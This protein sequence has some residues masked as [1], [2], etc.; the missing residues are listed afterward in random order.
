MTCNS[1]NA[2]TRCP[3][4]EEWPPLHR[5]SWAAA[6]KKGGL[7]DEP[8]RAA[9][10]RPATTEKTRKGYGA[11]LNWMRARGG[12]DCDLID[13]SRPEDF[14]TPDV[15][16]AYIDHLAARRSSMTVYNRIQELYGAIRVMAP[17][18]DWSWLKAAQDNLLGR[19]R[20]SRNKL[21]RLKDGALIE[22]LGMRLMA[23]AEA[24][25]KRD[26]RAGVGM[27]ELQRALAFRDG[28]MIALLIRRPFRIKNFVS[29]KDR[30]Q[31]H[32]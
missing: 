9:D 19:A 11:W 7:F 10:W 4:V 14:V 16:R 2:A 15:V 24:A 27:T 21:A 23:E 31:F 6:F 17:G 28:L 1:D 22:E 18:R 30:R 32:C 26:S 12:A 25:P 3:R 13:A 29:L 8:G 5:R 20:P